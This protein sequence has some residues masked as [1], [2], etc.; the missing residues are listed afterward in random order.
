MARQNVV[1]FLVNQSIERQQ[2]KLPIRHNNQTGPLKILRNRPE[3]QQVEFLGRFR[4]PLLRSNLREVCVDQRLETGTVG[5]GNGSDLFVVD[6]Q[7]IGSRFSQGVLQ[8]QLIWSEALLQLGKLDRL[9]L[10]H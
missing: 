1:T 9:T 8:D 3:K 5:Q 6:H 4:S 7:A 10:S 2:V